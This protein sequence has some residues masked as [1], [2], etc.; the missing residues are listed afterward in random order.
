MKS[1]PLTLINTIILK[2]LQKFILTKNKIVN[3][4][5]YISKG[6]SNMHRMDA[7]IPRYINLVTVGSA[8]F[9]VVNLVL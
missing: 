5:F 6:I 9:V 1:M 4:L 3:N 8:C 2:N 7:N